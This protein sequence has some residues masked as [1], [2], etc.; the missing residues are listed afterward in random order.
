VA[1]VRVLE[2]LNAQ[3]F[4]ALLWDGHGWSGDIGALAILD[5]T[6]LLDDDGRVRIEDVR[7]A[8]EPR[9]HRGATVPAAPVPAP[10]GTGL[11]GVGGRR[12]VRPGQSRP[13][14][15]ARRPGESS[16]TAGGM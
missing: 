12:R 11:A 5:G 3:D 15:S 10:P 14:A 4:G 8:L 16:T 1:T 7:R 2:R 13:G 9:L 6:S